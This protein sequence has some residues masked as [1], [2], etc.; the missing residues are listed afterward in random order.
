MILLAGMTNNIKAIQNMKNYFQEIINKFSQTMADSSAKKNNKEQKPE[1]TLTPEQQTLVNK[2]TDNLDQAKS[3][4]RVLSAT[5]ISIIESVAP[6]VQTLKEISELINQSYDA[7]NQPELG[8]L[9]ITDRNT[10]LLKYRNKT[11]NLFN[12]SKETI[13]S[14]IANALDKEFIQLKQQLANLPQEK[15]ES[16]LNEMQEK[17][18]SL[19]FFN[20]LPKSLLELKLG[21]KTL[22]KAYQEIQDQITEKLGQ[23]VS[24]ETDA[25]TKAEKINQI[26]Q[27]LTEWEALDIN[28]ITGI[29]DLQELQQKI[30]NLLQKENKDFAK[31]IVVEQTESFLDR[32][33][34][35]DQKIKDKLIIL[36]GGKPAETDTTTTETAKMTSSDLD[37]KLFAFEAKKSVFR[38]LQPEQKEAKIAE[39]LEL[40]QK[41][42]DQL[43][44]IGKTSAKTFTERFQT[45]ID[46]LNEEEKETKS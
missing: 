36:T 45:L 37:K 42:Y 46:Y 39:I 27:I 11:A 32:A 16:K 10:T 44:Q 2:A 5:A 34:S 40:W 21:S 3:K 30:F 23:A 14:L 22:E 31:E 19:N 8:K 26:N 24:T 13:F 1:I 15:P 6:A 33:K 4:M 25:K 41:N 18:K 28:S 38:K 12:K 43:D 29:N 9:P 7:E 20:T 35:L 17:L